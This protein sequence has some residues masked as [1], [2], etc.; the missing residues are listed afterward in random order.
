MKRSAQV[1]AVASAC[2]AMWVSTAQAQQEDQPAPD[3]RCPVA[4]LMSADTTKVPKE[5]Q[6]AARKGN[7]GRTLVENRGGNANLV[8]TYG[9]AGNLSQEMP[10]IYESCSPVEG[11]FEC[12]RRTRERVFLSRGD[13]TLTPGRGAD[14]DRGRLVTGVT[15]SDLAFAGFSGYLGSAGPSAILESFNDTR[16]GRAPNNSTNPRDCARAE[17]RTN[18]LT[19]GVDLKRGETM[20]YR[21]NQGRFGMLSIQGVEG[22]TVQIRQRTLR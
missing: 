2:L 20:C 22:F 6:R 14:L 7:L 1:F 11:G 13:I 3:V 10:E 5:W 18:R 21:T 8:C 15:E 12:Q 16:F 17:L 19:V 9:V 4:S